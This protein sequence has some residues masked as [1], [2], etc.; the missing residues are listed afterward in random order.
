MLLG[1]ALRPHQPIRT[2]RSH[3]LRNA[4]MSNRMN[5]FRVAKQAN[6]K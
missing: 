2:A 6:Q 1:L 4:P 3:D 5:I